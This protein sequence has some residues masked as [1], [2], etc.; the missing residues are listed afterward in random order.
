M[1]PCL[2]YYLLKKKINYHRLVS[3]TH[4]IFNFNKSVLGLKWAVGQEERFPRASQCNKYFSRE[5]THPTHLFLVRLKFLFAF[6][7]DEIKK[8]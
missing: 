6:E 4:W 8:K 3:Q 1:T 5:Y 7:F 2:P